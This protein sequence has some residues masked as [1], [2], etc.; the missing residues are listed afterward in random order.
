[1][2]FQ[3][4]QANLT[5]ITLQSPI[6]HGGV[7]TLT[8]TNVPTKH[9]LIRKM[10]W[11]IRVLSNMSVEHVGRRI[12]SIFAIPNLLLLV[13]IKHDFLSKKTFL[14]LKLIGIL[15]LQT[16]GWSLWLIK[17][18]SHKTAWASSFSTDVQSKKISNDQELIQS[19]P[20]S[21]IAEPK[22][23]YGQ[24]E[25]VTVRNHN[26]SNALEQSV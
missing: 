7:L 19:D 21:I 14:L 6:R 18:P 9:S 20:T 11:G 12:R 16:S 1:M 13:P 3:N 5:K 8:T 17:V 4:I 26:K 24:Q 25:Q 15:R 23:K 22:D 10:Y 2:C